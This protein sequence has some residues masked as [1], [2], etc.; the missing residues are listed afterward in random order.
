MI[1]LYVTDF[2][3]IFVGRELLFDEAKEADPMKL[4]NLRFR[5]RSL[6]ST[7]DGTTA[8]RLNELKKIVCQRANSSDVGTFD[9][10]SEP[11]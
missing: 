6:E 3:G 10:C 9:K 7:I 5:I 8:A 4:I 11:N 1:R 2:T